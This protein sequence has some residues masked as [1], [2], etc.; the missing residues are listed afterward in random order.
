MAAS[1]SSDCEK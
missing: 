1:A